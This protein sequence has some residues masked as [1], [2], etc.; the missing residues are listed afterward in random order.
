MNFKTSMVFSLISGAI[1]FCSFSFKNQDVLKASAERG[2]DVYIN[3]CQS[4][5]MDNGEGMEGTFPPLAKSDFLMKDIKR[6]IHV[7]LE[8]QAD[9]M[10]VNGKTYS[11]PMPAMN[12]LTDQQVSDV[13]NFIRNSWGNKGALVTEKQVKELRKTE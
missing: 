1:F 5:H 9:E 6:S 10:T 11:T 4:C 7:V 8:G 12:S 13:L 2:K 3:N